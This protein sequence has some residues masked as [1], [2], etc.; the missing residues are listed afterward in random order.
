MAILTERQAWRQSRDPK[1]TRRSSDLTPEEQ[2]HVRAALRWLAKRHGGVR[3]LA[4]LLRASVWTVKRERRA[5]AP[6]AVGSHPGGSAGRRE[7]GGRAQ[8]DVAAGRGVSALWPVL[9]W[10]T[11]A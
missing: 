10:P 11:P 6:S 4:G 8:R 5:G 7:R 2:G 1:T 3:K 9:T